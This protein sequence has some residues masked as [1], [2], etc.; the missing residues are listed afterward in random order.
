MPG[1]RASGELPSVASRKDIR[2]VVLG[3]APRIPNMIT[4]ILQLPQITRHWL[5]A[6]ECMMLLLR[7]FPT[8]TCTLLVDKIM[9]TSESRGTVRFPA[10]LNS[11]MPHGERSTA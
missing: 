9:A 5:Q 11:M 7:I 4:L 8:F 3:A 2:V 1:L 10:I 6:L